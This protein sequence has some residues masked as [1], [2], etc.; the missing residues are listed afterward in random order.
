MP[1][2]TQ[3]MYGRIEVTIREA[4]NNTALKYVGVSG[5]VQEGGMNLM[6]SEFFRFSNH[7]MITVR[8]RRSRRR[9]LNEGALM[10]LLSTLFYVQPAEI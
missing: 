10:E 4:T 2:R 6:S 1:V 8:L 3:R 9:P 5:R 7:H